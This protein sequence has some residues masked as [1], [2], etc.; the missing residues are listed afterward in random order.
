MTLLTTLKK[1]SVKLLFCGAIVLT[2]LGGAKLGSEISTAHAAP[3]QHLQAC[4]VTAFPP[5]D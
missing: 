1:R 5:C 3:A 2:L 4:G